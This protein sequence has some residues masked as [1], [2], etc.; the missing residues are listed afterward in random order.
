MVNHVRFNKIVKKL[1]NRQFGCKT[2]Y[3]YHWNLIVNNQPLKW[4]ACEKHSQ[5]KPLTTISLKGAK[6]NAT[7]N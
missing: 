4:L 5:V 6:Q 2:F 7:N 3:D 1:D